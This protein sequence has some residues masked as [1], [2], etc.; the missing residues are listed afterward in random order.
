MT[1]ASYAVNQILSSYFPA[2]ASHFLALHVAD[3]TT[4]GLAS[5]EVSTVATPVY[6]R[7]PVAWSAPANRGVYN[8]APV[9][10]S[11]L[12]AMEIGYLGVW[13]AL[14]NGNLLASLACPQPLTVLTNGQ[15]IYLP[16]GS[17]A[18][19]IGGSP[20]QRA[21]SLVTL[22]PD[23]PVVNTPATPTTPDVTTYAGNN[24]GLMPS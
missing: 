22:A 1:L 19:T 18:I 13:D 10:W 11:G 23:N 5:T 2:D 6:A 4:A 17:L 21:S 3:P 15:S 8:T 24:P 14:T 12:P 9:Q 20:T 7:K 16:P